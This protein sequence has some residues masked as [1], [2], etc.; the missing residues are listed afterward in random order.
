[1]RIHVTF[2]YFVAVLPGTQSIDASAVPVLERLLAAGDVNARAG[3]APGQ[4]P[5]MLAARK[6]NT[7]VVELL[8]RHGADVNAQDEIG[9]TALMCAID[10]GN[11]DMV[12]LLIA[13]PELN[14]DL[15]D[16]VR[17]DGILAH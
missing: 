13:R 15:K 7:T 5:L 3:T 11:L 4:T 6:A 1:M 14:L 8:L 9:N 17:R 16:Q 12:R 2:V 10:C